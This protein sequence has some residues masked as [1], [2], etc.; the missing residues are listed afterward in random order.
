MTKQ[1]PDN[2]EK[3]ESV[4]NALIEITKILLILLVGCVAV[5]AILSVIISAV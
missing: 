1:K 4:P 2:N 5:A 3:T